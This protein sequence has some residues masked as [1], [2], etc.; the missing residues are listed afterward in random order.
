MEVVLETFKKDEFGALIHVGH[1]TKGEILDI[2]CQ[3][4]V[5]AMTEDIIQKHCLFVEGRYII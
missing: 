1:K 3:Q 5:Q 4:D 2:L